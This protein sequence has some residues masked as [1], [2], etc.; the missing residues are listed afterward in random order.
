MF[1]QAKTSPTHTHMIIKRIRYIKPP[2]SNFNI[3]GRIVHKKAKGCSYFYKLLSVHDKSYGWEA[4]CCCMERDLVD[5]DPNYI[6]EREHFFLNVKRIMNLNFFNRI[7]QFMIRLFHNNLFLGD[8]A[9]NKMKNITQKCY[10]FG[11]HPETRV[12][13]MMNCSRT[14][15][16]LQFLIRILKKS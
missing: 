2:I 12:E 8:K 9:S 14:N 15:N 16:I 13:L 3:Y 6:F 11:S 1:L 4:S 5:F 7:K 10:A